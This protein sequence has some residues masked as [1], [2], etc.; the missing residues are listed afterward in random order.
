MIEIFRTYIV[1]FAIGL[2]IGIERERSHPIGMQAIGVR[3]FILCALLGALTAEI[4]KVWLTA[5]LSIFL[6][7]AILLGYLRSTDVHR[8]KVD[9]GLTTEIAAAVVYCL[10]YIS[11]QKPLLA[12]VLGVCIL[13]V[14]YSRKRLHR[15]VRNKLKPQEIQ[16]TVVILII[17]LG[18][19][20]FL[21]NRPIDPWQ[22]FN[23]QR[24][25]ILVIILSLM[26]FG[27]YL[28][29][30]IFGQ[31]LGMLLGGF[32]GGLVSS[33]VVFATL[34]RL[35][36]QYTNLTMPAVLAALY[37]F[38]AMLVELVIIL[39]VATPY[40]TI[41]ILP[42]V[43]AMIIVS[44]LLSLFV[45]PRSKKKDVLQEY[46]NPLDFLSVMRLAIFIGGMLLLVAVTRRYFGIY[47]MQFVTFLGALFELH[48]VALATATFY[49]SNKLAL[50]E[51]ELNLAV[52]ILATFVS[53]FFLIWSLARNRFAII[54]SLF[55]LFILGVGMGVYWLWA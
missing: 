2:I 8:R 33:T 40:L 41:R 28:A 30:R 34:S 12:S 53:K 39:F 13:L 46:N 1:A 37:A 17:S 42:P 49:A 7:A 47:G 6:F 54:T 22:L 9:I 4:D 20:S 31:Q 32:F 11:V 36:R 50:S 24:F 3:T 29:I 44:I 23:P 52:A 5:T 55:M 48:A 21:P 35:S 18:V 43:S 19:L 25:G 27:G 16:A 14:L 15:F 45:I 10:G 51:A 38:I 26:Q